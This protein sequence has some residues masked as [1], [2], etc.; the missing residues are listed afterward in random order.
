MYTCSL[1]GKPIQILDDG[2]FIRECTHTDAGVI[3]DLSA[4]CVGTGGVEI[5][6][7]QDFKL[8]DN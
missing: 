7:C 1:C 6:E 4:H 5:P 8:L 3:A 2:V